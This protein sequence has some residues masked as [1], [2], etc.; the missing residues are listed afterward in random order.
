MCGSRHLLSNGP[1]HALGLEQYI[2]VLVD[3][4]IAFAGEEIA[5]NENALRSAE[6]LQLVLT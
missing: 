6:G 5:I 1:V 2:V 4:Q 3:Q